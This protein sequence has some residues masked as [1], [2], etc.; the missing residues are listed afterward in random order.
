MRIENLTTVEDNFWALTSLI[1][2]G[3]TIFQNDLTVTEIELHFSVKD[4]PF[5]VSIKQCDKNQIHAV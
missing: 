5:N 4:T 3:H 1:K 2:N